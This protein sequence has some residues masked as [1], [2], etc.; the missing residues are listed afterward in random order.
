MPIYLGQNKA[1]SVFLDYGDVPSELLP[2]VKP[3][4]WPDIRKIL[5]DDVPPAGYVKTAIS[6]MYFE[7]GSTDKERYVRLFNMGAYKTSQMSTAKTGLSYTTQYYHQ[8]TAGGWQYIIHYTPKSLNKHYYKIPIQD[9]IVQL[10]GNAH[11]ALKWIHFNDCEVHSTSIGCFGGCTG[12]E[13]MTGIKGF[14]EES[15]NT[16]SG[17]GHGTFAL[18]TQRNK[19]IEGHP[20]IS[21]VSTQ[22]HYTFYGCTDL[23]T[24]YGTLDT[25]TVTI[26]KFFFTN[27]SKLVAITEDT[28]FTNV[29][30]AESMFE[31]CVSLPGVPDVFSSRVQNAT[32]M[33]ADCMSLEKIPSSLT[34]A[35][36]TVTENMFLNNVKL[37][38]VPRTFSIPKCTNAKEMFSG[39]F[40]L[41]TIDDN[42]KTTL[43]QNASRMFAGCGNLRT[44]G[45]GFTLQNATDVTDMLLY[46]A[47]LYTLP[48]TLDLRKVTEGLDTLFQYTTSLHNIPTTLLANGNINLSYSNDI[49]PEKFAKFE[50]GVLT[51]GL[52]YNIN[53][54]STARTFKIH[55]ELK[56]KYSTDQWNKITAAMSA[57][58]WSI[59]L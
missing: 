59:G 40:N 37:S 1:H 10:N 29:T 55:S 4:S 15:K 41:T 52:V 31:K 43:L 3:A 49:D 36:M 44:I 51:G 21:F 24:L 30:D 19:I 12:L 53:Q 35:N 26:A 46:C 14:F 25:K 50:D 34:G 38:E 7:A 20:T 9:Y 48:D 8:F 32:R 13:A 23:K 54:V 47:K 6:L 16:K 5:E 2:W 18:N 17:I 57:K 11:N 33:F 58:N 42:F 28:N 39:C 22:G 27:C 45:T 56:A